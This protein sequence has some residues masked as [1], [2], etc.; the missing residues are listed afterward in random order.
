MSLFFTKFLYILGPQKTNFYRKI[1]FYSSSSILDLLVLSLLPF[2]IAIFSG[3]EVKNYFF[4]SESFLREYGTIYYVGCLILIITILKAYI[5]YLSIFKIVSFVSN[6]QRYNRDKIFSF[7]KDIFLN[8]FISS[9]FEKFLNT[10]SYIVGV[11]SENILFKLITIISEIIII[12]II[13]I[14]LSFVN[15][16][17][18]LGLF[19]FFFTLLFIYFLLIKKFITSAGKLQSDSLEKLTE[20]INN[21]FKGLKEI[22]IFNLS[23]FFDKKFNKYNNEYTENFIHY[24]KLVF[25]PKYLLESLIIV[26]IILLFFSLSAFSGNP[27]STYF[28]LIGIFIFAGLRITPLAYNIFSSL[29]QIY[30]SKYSLDTIYEEFKRIDGYQDKIKN[31]VDTRKVNRIDKF[32]KL[33]LTNICFSYT[34]KKDDLILN[35]FN[36]TINKGECIG[37]KGDSGSGKTTFVNILLGLIYPDSGGIL[38]NENIDAFSSNIYDKMSYTPQDSFLINGSILENI[39]LGKSIENLE[40]EKSKIFNI[41]KTTRLDVSL[42]VNKENF[43]EL[44]SVRKVDTLSGGQAQRVA[45]CRNLY[46][47]REIN[48]FDEFTSSLDI[49]TEDKIVEFFNSMKR[50]NTIII[51]SHRINAL[52][53]C[54]RVFEVSNGGLNEIKKIEKL[55]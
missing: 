38:V 43:M 13:S 37:I 9:K 22:K 8:D 46:F 17:A 5:N 49:K 40:L 23:N 55:S 32:H 12:L 18:L 41:L 29:S 20:V 44:L 39:A 30:S 3:S 21:V 45:I 36:L 4:F 52:K 27:I 25:L 2:L 51:I 16:Y 7:Y 14:Y 54:D 11:F 1:I 31:K 50:T 15:F 47:N 24:Q 35:N 6:I 53:Y 28:E 33:S 19:I 10:T 42:N 34:K 48:I 26:F